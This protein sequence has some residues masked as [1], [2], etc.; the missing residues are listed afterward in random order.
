[1][2]RID[3]H[4]TI[5]PSYHEYLYLYSLSQVINAPNARLAT[6]KKNQDK[7]ISWHLVYS[8]LQI[9]VTA[10]TLPFFEYCRQQLQESY[11][12]TTFQPFPDDTDLS[13]DACHSVI[14]QWYRTSKTSL[15]HSACSH[16]TY[17]ACPTL[18]GYFSPFNLPFLTAPITAASL[19]D[20][21]TSTVGSEPDINTPNA[22]GDRFLIVAI[23]GTLPKLVHIILSHPDIQPNL[24]DAQGC[25]P[26][27]HAAL[28]CEQSLSLLLDDPRILLDLEN[29]AGLTAWGLATQ[30]HR[31]DSADLLLSSLRDRTNQ[32]KL[33]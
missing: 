20:T 18:S 10:Y 27:M 26:L 14:T 13:Y 8:A 25:T 2:L 33:V 28:S 1:M 11:P 31:H 9:V 5:D 22:Q 16:L 7:R 32:K 3:A 29:H 12:I 6:P 17:L 23:K 30:A 24:A 4:N 15:I 21:D 19:H